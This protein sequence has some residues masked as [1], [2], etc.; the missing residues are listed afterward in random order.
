METYA[1]PK[2]E[3]C[4]VC[5]DR[6]MASILDLG[7]MTLSGVFPPLDAPAPQAFPVELVRCRGCGL[8][9]LHHNYARDLLY[10][11]GYGYQSGINEQMVRHLQ[12]IAHAMEESVPLR[13]G[14]VVLDIGSN[15][16]TLLSKYR[17]AGIQRIGMDPLIPHL[18]NR[19]PEGAFTVADYFS[20]AR[21]RG[22]FA[23]KACVITSVAM[24]YDL[25]VPDAFVADIAECLADDGVW[26]LEQSYLPSMLDSVSF[27]TI[28][29][30]HL[31][32]YRLSDIHRLVSPHGLRIFDVSLNAANGGSFRVFV[33]HEASWRKPSLRVH[34][35]LAVEATADMESRLS[36]FCRRTITA[37]AALL[38]LLQRL[39][40]ESKR[41]WIYGAST[42]GNVL[43]QYCGIGRDLA[44]AAADRNPAKW[45][46]RTPGTD[47]PILSEDEMR[48]VAPDYLLVL[49]W[50]FRD[51]FV[52][53]EAVY[54]AA[55]GKMIF[56][57][58]E[59]AII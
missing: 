32:Y 24:F 58:P 48:R 31:E 22:H 33:C 41:V 40:R 28:C 59:L 35:I 56:P 5:G 11:A 55:G 7:D 29:H 27:D 1:A 53:R 2:I 10:H 14:D 50:H 39:K 42:K 45:G 47:I 6:D 3:R 25:P 4:R 43:L 36:D 57:L 38:E 37:R 30:E 54:L 13:A 52:K 23:M 17:T 49:P 16:G 19:Y 21:Y 34:E 9:Q 20:A 44:E 12:E 18:P 51:G 15:D 46:T 8:V 26:M